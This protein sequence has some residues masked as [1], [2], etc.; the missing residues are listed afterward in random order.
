M[1]KRA[2][3]VQLTQDNVDEVDEATDEV[4]SNFQ[5]MLQLSDGVST[6]IYYSYAFVGASLYNFICALTS[7]TIRDGVC[8]YS[9]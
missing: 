8:G 7:F 1:S 4:N 6:S 3:E 9:I 5:C 2:A